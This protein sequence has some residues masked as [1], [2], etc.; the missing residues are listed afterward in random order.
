MRRAAALGLLAMSTVLAACGADAA[1]SSP[2][3]S[4][5]PAAVVPG[6][7]GPSAATRFLSRYV[8]ADGRVLRRDQ[9]SDIVS[10][11]QAY[12]MLIAEVAGAP[13]VARTIWTWTRQHLARADGLFAW[14]ASGDGQIEDSQSA[15]DGDVLIAYALLSYRGAG[16]G[17]LHGAGRRVAAAVLAHESATLAGGAPLPVAG[18]WALTAQPLVVDPS[19]L[20]PGVFSALATATGDAR[21]GAA[22]GASISLVGALTHG[23]RRLPP[24]WA[25][26]SGGA[27]TATAAP[28]GGAGVQYGLDAQRIPIWF[29]ASCDPTARALAAAWWKLLQKGDRAG[30][31]ALSL[32]GATLNGASNPLPLLAAAAAASAA[33]DSAAASALSARALAQSQRTP[34]YYGDAW[35]VLAGALA[36]GGLAA[37]R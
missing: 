6:R 20:A 15:T 28:G 22:A 11:G 13:A 18:P 10:E 23:G 2:T 21:W 26:L 31:L 30:A 24:D 8:T 37:C 12:G 5:P 33:G 17:E 27:L 3:T 36:S 32:T 9:G 14:H 19:Y 7:K 29:A 16:A 35:V 34:T 25:A 4:R 1:P